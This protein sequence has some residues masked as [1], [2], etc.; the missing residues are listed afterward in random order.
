MK[1][2]I[3]LTPLWI[4]DQTELLNLI[5]QLRSEQRLAIDTES[6]SLYA[7]QEQVCLIQISTPDA[8]YL[9]DTINIHTV[10]GQSFF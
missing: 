10:E 6:N 8:D 7:Y 3:S 2:D 9:L 1:D 4:E 5:E